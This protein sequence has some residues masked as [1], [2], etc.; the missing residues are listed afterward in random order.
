MTSRQRTGISMLPVP[1]DRGPVRSSQ[2]PGVS[3]EPRALSLG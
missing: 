3:R 1:V 2:V